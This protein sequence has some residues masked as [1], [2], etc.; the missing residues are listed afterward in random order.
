MGESSEPG[1]LMNAI[2]VLPSSGLEATLEYYRTK[3]GF[4]G[5]IHGNYLILSR[6]EVQLHFALSDDDHDPAKAPMC[7][8]GVRGIDQL[9]AEVSRGDIIPTGGELTTEPWGMRQFAVRDEDG[10]CIVFQEPTGE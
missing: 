1:R 9:Y 3:L 5:Q 7:R 4:E 10:N 8:V 2:P 6:D